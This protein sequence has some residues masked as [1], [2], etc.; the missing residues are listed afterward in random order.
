MSKHR[1]DN[2]CASC[3]EAAH[4]E[5]PLADNLAGGHPLALPVLAGIDPPEP[6]LPQLL[7]PVQQVVTAQILK[8]LPQHVHRHLPKHAV[9]QRGH[10][11]HL[12]HRHVSSLTLTLVHRLAAAVHLL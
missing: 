9:H 5:V 12:R 10:L 2:L 4:P 7:L 8:R 11:A 6:P 3:T 1:N